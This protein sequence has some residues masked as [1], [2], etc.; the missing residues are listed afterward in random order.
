MLEEETNNKEQMLCEEREKLFTLN[1]QIKLREQEIS[2][3]L[4]E[5]PN[6][7]EENQFAIKKYLK[8]K[9]NKLKNLQ[10]EDDFMSNCYDTIKNMSVNN[11]RRMFNNL[12][13]D[14]F[15]SNSIDQPVLGCFNNKREFSDQMLRNINQA[16]VYYNDEI[17]RK[18]PKTLFTRI[19]QAFDQGFSLFRS[20]CLTKVGRGIILHKKPAV[21]TGIRL[22]GKNFDP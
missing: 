17:I 9:E 5:L 6:D 13:I 12:L 7:T 4:R 19:L 16:D 21:S 1:E 20:N 18:M 2:N 10:G 3:K 14:D 8:S 22:D 11:S 15:N